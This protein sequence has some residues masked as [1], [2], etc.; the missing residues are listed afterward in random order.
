MTGNAEMIRT[1]I[2]TRGITNIRVIDALTR[3]DRRMF[4]PD[5]QASHAYE[6]HPIPLMPGSTVSQPYIVA[7][8]TDLLDVQPHHRVLEI[9]SGSGYQAAVLS[10][11]A[12]EIWAL[13]VQPEM[14][15]PARSWRS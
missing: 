14:V 6:D 1:Q 2:Q 10:L 5:E 13:E 7:L 15:A 4:V 9:G 12:K 3:T 8:M 11:L